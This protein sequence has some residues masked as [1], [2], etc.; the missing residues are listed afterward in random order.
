VHAGD[1]DLG[2]GIG[3]EA[4]GGHRVGERLVD[5]GPVVGLAEPVLPLLRAHVAGRAPAVGELP[6]GGA[7]AEV[8]GQDV[9]VGVVTDHQRGGGVAPGALVGAAGQAGADVG[10]HDERRLRA[11]EGHSQGGDRRADRAAEVGGQDVVGQVEGGVDGGGVGLVDV[12]RR[13]GREP[14]GAGPRGH[15]GHGQPGRLDAHRRRVLVVRRHRPGAR[16]AAR[17]RHRGDGRPVEPPVRKVGGRRDD[18]S[19]GRQSRVGT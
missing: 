15:R 12:G 3:G 16:A 9:A 6:G 18:P 17:S 14:E 7:G 13:H 11:V 2:D 8:L 4:G 5:Q 1:D 10:G 19:H